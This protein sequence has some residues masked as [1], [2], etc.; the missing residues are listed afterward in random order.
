MTPSK[1]LISNYGSNSKKEEYQ[2]PSIA[3]T[4]WQGQFLTGLP[5]LLAKRCCRDTTT[6]IRRSYFFFWPPPL[7]KN[8]YLW[9]LQHGHSKTFYPKIRHN[10]RE[11]WFILTRETRC[12]WNSFKIHQEFCSNL[13]TPLKKFRPENLTNNKKKALFY[14]ILLHFIFAIFQTHLATLKFVHTS[15][16]AVL[17]EKDRIINRKRGT[18]ICTY[19]CSIVCYVH[20]I[21][22]YRGSGQN[23]IGICLCFKVFFM[24][25]LCRRYFLLISLQFFLRFLDLSRIEWAIETEIYIR[26]CFAVAVCLS[27]FSTSV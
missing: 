6:Q 20:N 16:M 27:L 5:R 17:A 13:L 12:L 1:T 10:Q 23:F 22:T 21:C 24:G 2:W 25:F 15:S 9:S 3:E 26:Q 7:K 18:T 4:N 14:F 11:L 19:I 8:Y